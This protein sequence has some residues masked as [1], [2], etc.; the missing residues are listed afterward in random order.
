[1][2]KLHIKRIIY[3]RFH[4][5]TYSWL[6]IVFKLRGPS[7]NPSYYRWWW[8]L[9]L[10][11]IK[12]YLFLNL[13]AL[14]FWDSEFVGTVRVRYVSVDRYAAECVWTTALVRCYVSAAHWLRS[15]YLFLIPHTRSKLEHHNTLNTYIQVLV[16]S[17]MPNLTACMHACMHGG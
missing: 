8:S 17:V 7:Y 13:W 11:C 12:F 4:L 2:N 10:S 16:I 6:W 9:R 3:S 1:M 5:Y 14:F 15:A